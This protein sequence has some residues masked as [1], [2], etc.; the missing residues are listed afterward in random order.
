ME[1]FTAGTVCCTLMLLHLRP[2]FFMIAYLN[3]QFWI[4]INSY[5]HSHK[6]TQQQDDT[7]QGYAQ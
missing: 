4:M 5:F 3:V 6:T 7:F 1:F 2:E